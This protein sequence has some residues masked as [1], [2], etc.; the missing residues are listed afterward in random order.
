MKCLNLTVVVLFLFISS[1]MQVIVEKP[2]GTR[3][4]IN[5]FCYKLSIDEFMTDKVNI[6]NYEGVPDK[7]KA[8]TPYGIMETK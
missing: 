2:D 7:V 3:Y 1:C 5:T 4:K 8:I 6:K